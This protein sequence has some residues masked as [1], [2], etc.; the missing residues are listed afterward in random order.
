MTDETTEGKTRIRAAW[1]TIERSNG[2]CHPVLRF[3][4]VLPRD[5]DGESF[6][7]DGW[8]SRYDMRHPYT[9][10]LEDFRVTA[11]GESDEP[12]RFYGW[13][14]EFEKH[15][16]RSENMAGMGKTFATLERALK[17]TRT[18]AGEAGT[19]AD[20]A[21][22]VCVALKIECLYVRR[23]DHAQREHMHSRYVHYGHENIRDGLYYG[24]RMCWTD[25]ERERTR[26]AS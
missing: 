2:Y 7:Y 15:R 10:D 16:V 3:G 19:W 14:L 18:T 25:G 1:L 11:Q 26:E 22:R 23:P 6:R 8:T 9:L 13:E 24:S 17:K 5:Y 20:Y 12:D 21:L 4:S